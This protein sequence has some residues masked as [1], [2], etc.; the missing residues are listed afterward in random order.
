MKVPLTKK[1][2]MII[3]IVVIALAWWFMSSK[4]GKGDLVYFFSPNCPHCR[5][6]M[7]VWESVN[8]PSGVGKKKIDCSTQACLGIEALPTIMMNGDEFSGERTK[9]NIEAFVNKNM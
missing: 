9:E 5:D 4:S 3:G 1:Q 7:P 8:V 6:F 2:I